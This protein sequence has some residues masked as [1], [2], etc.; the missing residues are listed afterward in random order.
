MEHT[1]SHDFSWRVGYIGRDHRIWDYVPSEHHRWNYQY[2]NIISIGF[3]HDVCDWFAWGPFVRWDARCG[4]LDETGAWF[5]IL[6][7]CLGFRFAVN[8]ENGVRRID[9]SK[10]S[11][12]MEVAF[13]I[14]LRALGSSSMLDLAKF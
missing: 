4:E 12:D 14:Y 13:A 9:G 1:V 8:Y 6:T 3:K 10:F 11:S 7:D 5:D 2:S